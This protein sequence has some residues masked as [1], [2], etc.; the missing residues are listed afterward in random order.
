MLNYYLLVGSGGAVGAVTRYWLSSISYQRF[1]HGFPYGTLIVNFSGSLV[2]G[3][4][5][6]WL[7]NR[8]ALDAELRALLIVGFLGA[9]TTFSAFSVETLILLEQGAWMKGL[10]YVGLSVTLCLAAAGAGMWLARSI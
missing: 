3:F 6:F 7:V 4:L 5:Y 8:F 10:A 9:F 1:G 2:I